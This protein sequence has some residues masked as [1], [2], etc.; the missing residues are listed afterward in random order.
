DLTGIP[1]P[2]A[3]CVLNSEEKAP[4][5]YVTH[6]YKKE[7]YLNACQYPIQPVKSSKFWP[8]TGLNPILPPPFKK[9]PGRPKL[10]RRKDP[11]EPKK[12]RV[13]KLARTRRRMTCTVC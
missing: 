13:G 6:W 12:Q 5:D 4:E 11:L 9:M 3:I 7:F 8:K 1:S 2:H 10:C